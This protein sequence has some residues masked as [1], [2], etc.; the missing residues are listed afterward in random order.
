MGMLPNQWSL[1]EI[2]FRALHYDGSVTVLYAFSIP[3]LFWT[4]CA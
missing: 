1:G 2:T 4:E 3:P